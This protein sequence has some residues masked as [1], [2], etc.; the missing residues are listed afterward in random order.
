MKDGARKEVESTTS[1]F[2]T[3]Q[4]KYTHMDNEHTYLTIHKHKHIY[5]TYTV[6]TQV[7]ININ[8]YTIHIQYILNYTETLTH[9]E[10]IR[11]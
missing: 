11:T 6:H 9:I 8:T 10:Y 2:G 1:R 3:A 5:N 4:H 7:Y